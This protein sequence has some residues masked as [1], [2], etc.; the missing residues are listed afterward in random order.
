MSK[1][2]EDKNQQR[3]ISMRR[4]S[5]RTRLCSNCHY[6]SRGYGCDTYRRHSDSLDGPII[7]TGTYISCA[8]F[9]QEDKV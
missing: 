6:N 4:Q 2:Q 8:R 7:D 3:E 1:E 9:I 5:F